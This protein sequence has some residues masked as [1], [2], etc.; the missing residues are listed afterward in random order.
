[1]VSGNGVL[2][3]GAERKRGVA[4]KRFAGGQL[5]RP[6]ARAVDIVTA[7]T[8]PRALTCTNEANWAA[9]HGK[10]D[11]WMICENVG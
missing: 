8:N 9:I 4:G 1:M 11:K 5:L 2:W 10:A 7:E 3:M 6:K